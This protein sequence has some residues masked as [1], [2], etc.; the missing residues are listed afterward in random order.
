MNKD[1][2]CNL[3]IT[4]HAKS[5]AQFRFSFVNRDVAFI[6]K[7]MNTTDLCDIK[8]PQVLRRFICIVAEIVLHKY[9]AHGWCCLNL[10]CR[11]LSL[12][13]QQERS[14]P[15]PTLN[16]HEDQVSICR[17]RVLQIKEILP[18]NHNILSSVK[19]D[20]VGLHLCGHAQI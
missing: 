2:I 7:L 5:K 17:S 20:S 15:K 11:Q 9:L 8:Y 6:F 16:T 14:A 10:S 4:R 18:K 13:H 3:L 1:Y 19:T 12:T